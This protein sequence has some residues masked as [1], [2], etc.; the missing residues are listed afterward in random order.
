MTG[1]IELRS[2]DSR[3]HEELEA[4]LG[5]NQHWVPHVGSLTHGSL[6]DL[7]AQAELAL[8]AFGAEG[9]EG[10]V[11]VLAQGADY[12]SPNY[13]W[14]AQRNDEFTYVDRIAI[15]PR[16]QGLGL[17]RTL[18]DA[19]AGHGRAAGSPVLCAEV[20]VDPPNPQSQAFHT[21]MGFVEVGRQWTYGDTVEVQMLEKAL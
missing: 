6:T 12:S 3:D 16:A 5:L 8:G 21:R 17:G 1:S 2:I 4:V 9:L 15:D 18:Y 11:I 14:F 7:L 13:R 10:F 19:A 20:N